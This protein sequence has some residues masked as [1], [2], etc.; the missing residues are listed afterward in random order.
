[1]DAVGEIVAHGVHTPLPA[2]LE[3]GGSQVVPLH[4]LA[5][6]RAGRYRLRL[7]LVHEH[8]RWFDCGVERE[9]EV[10]RRLRVALFGDEA[11]AAAMAERL[12]ED[13]PE[14]EP[15]VLSPDAREPRFGPPRA[16]D[17]REYLLHGTVPG[18]RRDWPVIL[19]RAVALAGAVEQRRRGLEARPLLHGGEEFLRELHRC[20]H[21]LRV[22]EPE[23]GLRETLLDRMTVRS[24]RRL[25]VIVVRTPGE[26]GPR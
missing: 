8:V 9:V 13:A 4:V 22:S 11:R 10:E 26:L 24:A 6:S 20:T 5:P 17:L 15:V 18:R 23:P 2:D 14:F 12:T 3:P 7:D 1:L 21:L 19:A 16:P 25:G